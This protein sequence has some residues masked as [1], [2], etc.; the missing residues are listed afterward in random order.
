MASIRLGAAA[1]PKYELSSSSDTADHGRAALLSSSATD[2]CGLGVSM[3]CCDTS[4]TALLRPAVVPSK[5]TPMV[6]ARR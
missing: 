3:L 4:W 6:L 1:G 5:A 2:A